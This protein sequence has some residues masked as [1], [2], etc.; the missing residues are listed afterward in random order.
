MSKLDSQ[1]QEVLIET[2]RALVADESVQV[3]FID[4]IQNN[5]FTWNQRLAGDKKRIE[6]P[7]ISKHF[8]ASTDLAACYILFHDSSIHQQESEQEFFDEFERVRVIAEVKNIYRGA[9]QN[10]LEKIRYDLQ[11]DIIEPFSAALEKSGIQKN[12]SLILLD[13]IFSQNFSNTI[14]KNLS[15][16]ITREIKNLSKKTSDQSAFA[17][18]VAKL[19]EML[20]KEEEAEESKEVK[21]K[22][23]KSKNNS[24][25]SNQE[26]IESEVES[27][28]VTESLSQS[29]SSVQSEGKEEVEKSIPMKLGL[30]K[31]TAKEDKIEF[32]KAY[33]IYTTKFDEVVF[34][35]KLT[36]K[37]ELKT[38]R[39][40]LDLRLVKLATTS[41]KM[42]LKLKR[43]LLSKRDFLLE[44][45]SSRGILDRKKLTRLVTNPL[46]DDVWVN[47]KN[48]QYQDTALTILLDNSGSMRGQ[49]IVM[50]ALACQIIA[51]ILEKFSVKTEIIGFTTSDW[52]G[53]RARKLW[54]SSGRPSNP[55]RLNELRHVIYKHFNQKFKKA[56]TNLGLMLK[57]GVLKENIDGEALLFARSRLMQQS[58]KRKILLVISDGTP[59]DDSTNSANDKDILTEHLHHVIKKIEKSR[60]VEIV[61]IGIGHSTDDFYRNSTAIKSPEELGDVMIE[62]VVD[63]L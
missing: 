26:N 19:L 34:P 36:S 56:K 61:G 38:L 32:K 21:E 12:L 52:K 57:E 40:Q 28:G 18:G 13:E 20:K 39:D 47:S 46:S 27:D 50:A 25:S 2:L 60:R 35:Q 62:K 37:Q 22:K 8:R 1:T 43:K 58:E 17:Q 11:S 15:K 9:A 30:E 6:V 14:E 54:E 48:H 5:F 24:P 31:S 44:F 59:V 53:G 41:K 63:L 33:K 51:E 45:D 55:G 23:S 16:K 4:E 49:P 42:T 3:E 7:Q 10:I 29:K